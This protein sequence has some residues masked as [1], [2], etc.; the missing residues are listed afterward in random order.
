MSW[1]LHIFSIVTDF[2]TFRSKWPRDILNNK[3]LIDAEVWMKN[4]N[5]KIIA[6][7]QVHAILV[8]TVWS[9]HFFSNLLFFMHTTSL[10][11]FFL[12]FIFVPLHIFSIVND[13]ITFRSKWLRDIL[14]NK[15][16]FDAEVSM[17]NNNIKIVSSHQVQKFCSFK[18]SDFLRQLYRD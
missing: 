14:N 18:S 4:D 1:L 16:L 7:H 6:S 12:K 8:L 9:N 3:K 13:L 15:K 17:R 10:E 5:I 11:I 2:I